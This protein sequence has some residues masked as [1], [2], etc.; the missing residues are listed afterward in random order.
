MIL[1]GANLR[2]HAHTAQQERSVDGPQEHQWHPQMSRDRRKI[3]T[4]CE[5][6][7]QFAEVEVLPLIDLATGKGESKSPIDPQ[8]KTEEVGQL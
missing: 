2:F 7:R 4:L 1:A 5:A 6:H 3:G 8:L